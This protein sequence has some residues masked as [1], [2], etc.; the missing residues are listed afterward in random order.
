MKDQ[1][2]KI[3]SI[4]FEVDVNSI[5]DDST[6]GTI[7]NWD[8]IRHMNLIVSIEEEFNLR[9]TDDEITDLLSFKLVE[10]IVSKKINN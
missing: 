3:M 10:S 1:I 6:P 4:V 2:K 8:S 7:E 9:F 5:E